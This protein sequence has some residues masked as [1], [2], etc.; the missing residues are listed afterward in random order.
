MA[1]CRTNLLGVKLVYCDEAGEQQ[2]VWVNLK[3]VQALSWCS[4]EVKGKGNGATGQ[5]KLPVDPNGP[6]ECHNGRNIP[7]DALCWWDGKEWI[8]GVE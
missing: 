5:H 1:N 4:G 6:G 3:K 2:E 8:C 7:D